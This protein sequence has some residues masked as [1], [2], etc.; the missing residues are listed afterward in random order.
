MTTE[1]S[2]HV[3]V[4]DIEKGVP[5]VAVPTEQSVSHMLA[6]TPDG[7][8]A[9]IANIGS[10]S[11][12]AVDLEAGKKLRDVKTGDGAEGIAITPD[13]REVWVGNRAADTVS[14]IDAASLEVVATLPCKGFPIRVAIT[15]NGERALVSCA[16]AGEVAMF[17]VPAREEIGRTKLDLSAL[18]GSERRLFGDRFG[19]SPVPIGLVIA[20][21][22]KR[23]WVAA[24]QSDVV[25]ALDLESF[26]V[27]GL[28]RA[29]KE[30]D[31][32]AYS[33]IEQAGTKDS[34]PG[35]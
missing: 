28:L 11:V 20:P 27:A 2:R 10:G 9:F 22:G 26:S 34:Q 18:P 21:D 16:R 33:P 31:G 15:P 3:L 13:G 7:K 1:G 14:V 4:V 30:P 19:Q 25:V 8:R 6:V 29:G 23:A 17:D 24:T 35:R 12:T 5:V 32:M